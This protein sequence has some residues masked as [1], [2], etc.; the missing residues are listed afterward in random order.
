[1]G[2]CP[3]GYS[4]ERR[5]V[6]QGYSPDNCL[7]IPRSR[8]AYNTS[9]TRWVLYEGTVMPFADA[10]RLSGLSAYKLDKVLAT[11]TVL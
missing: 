4:L 6:E 10:L 3:D 5:N 1:M 9:R 11:T 7:W 8:Q 2:L